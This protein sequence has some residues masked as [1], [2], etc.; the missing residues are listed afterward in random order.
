VPPYFPLG[1]SFTAECVREAYRDVIDLLADA[2]RQQSGQPE[3][4]AALKAVLDQ[5]AAKVREE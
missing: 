2:T 1:V 3:A 5:V 4:V